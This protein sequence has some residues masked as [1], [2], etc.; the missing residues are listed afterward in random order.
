MFY[1]PFSGA[2]LPTPFASVA[3]A[4]YETG[5]LA[6]II[7]CESAMIALW[8]Q[9]DE[10]VGTDPFQTLLPP[11][12]ISLYN[13]RWNQNA[14]YYLHPFQTKFNVFT[15]TFTNT[16]SNRMCAEYVNFVDFTNCCLGSQAPSKFPSSL[17]VTLLAS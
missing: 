4:P 3:L 7:P 9:E 13:F 11:S 5:T 8:D 17:I 6:T 10:T 16:P 2:Q 1:D 14:G 15:L 12:E